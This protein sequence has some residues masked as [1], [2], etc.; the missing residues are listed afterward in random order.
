MN[1]SEVLELTYYDTCN[2][3]RKEKV[4]NPDT[5]ITELIKVL[6]VSNA[7]CAVSKKDEVIASGDIGSY[8]RV[9]KLFCNPNTELKTGDEVEVTYSYGDIEVFEAG[10]PFKYP[11]SHLECPIKEAIRI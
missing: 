4:K 1:E 5:G 10:K 11:N 9:N 8:V 3:Y 2:I 6:K 7:K